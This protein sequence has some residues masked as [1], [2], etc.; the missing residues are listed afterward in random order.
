MPSAD[1]FGT[2]DSSLIDVFG[3]TVS[4]APKDGSGPFSIIGIFETPSMLDQFEPLGGA[5]ILRLFVRLADVLAATGTTPARGDVI[6][7]NGLT[8]DCTDI[9]VDA[10][11]GASLRLRQRSTY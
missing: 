5:A 1:T 11:G 9:L 10:L 6:S 4:F 7:I 3:D 8:Y 2:L